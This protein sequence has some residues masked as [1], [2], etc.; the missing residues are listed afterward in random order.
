MRAVWITGAGGLIGSHLVQSAPAFAPGLEAV[1]LTRERL[2]LG[3]F[4]AVRR[5]FARQR[6]AL[7][8]HCA[9]ISKSPDCQ[10]NPI[11]A[12]RVNVDATA[13]LADLASDIPLIFFSSDLVFDGRKGDYDETDSVNPLS[14]YAETKAEAERLVLA[15]PGHTV[16]RTS[17][18]SGTS[19]SGNRSFDEEA[20]AAW[21][22]GRVLTFF[23][24][25]FRCP[26][27]APVTARAVWELAARNRPGLYHLAGSE[28][29]SRLG[30]GQI[31]AA[32][33]PDL[34][35]QFIAASL[36]EHR[37]A[38]RAPDTSLNCSK[39]QKL[40]SFPLPRWSESH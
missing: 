37:G 18:N 7:V 11:L 28:R 21:R 25:E 14:V 34:H 16:V 24:D 31:L 30:I 6:P 9:A 40:L 39:I 8:I 22:A 32:R 2:D 29:L 13:L 5:E 19:P 26:I 20:E 17:L 27:A 10:A 15:N 33:R 35:P 1:G 36:K 12:R 4:N 23:S 38:P 3:D